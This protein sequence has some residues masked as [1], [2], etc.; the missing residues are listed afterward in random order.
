MKRVTLRNLGGP[1]IWNFELVVED[2]NISHIRT[3]SLVEKKVK[4]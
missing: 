4:Q 2:F 1:L 3:F